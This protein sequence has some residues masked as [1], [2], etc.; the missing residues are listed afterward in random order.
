MLSRK[1]RRSLDIGCSN[2]ALSRVLVDDGVET[3]GIEI[4][5]VFAAQAAGRLAVVLV[6]DAMEQT[7]SSMR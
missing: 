5:P 2:G 6:G 1:P 3:W 7:A 4:D